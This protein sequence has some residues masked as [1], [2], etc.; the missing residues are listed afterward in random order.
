MEAEQCLPSRLSRRVAN[1]GTNVGYRTA[2]RRSWSPRPVRT[3]LCHDDAEP[4]RCAHHNRRSLAHGSRAGW[5]IDFV[6]KNRL[7]T[8]YIIKENVVAGGLMSYGPSIA[9]LFRRAAGFVQKILQGAKPADLP[10]EQPVKFELF[11]NLKT[12]TAL[13]L[14]FPRSLLATADDVIE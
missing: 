12:A 7:P 4:T 2:V 13:G 5:I 9:D 11:I 10:I 14:T 6:A 8:I 1:C 3:R